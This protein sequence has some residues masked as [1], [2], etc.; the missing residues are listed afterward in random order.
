MIGLL[1]SF[2]DQIN[3]CKSKD[4]YTYN[5]L[6]SRS[7]HRRSTTGARLLRRDPPP[8]YPPALLCPPPATTP[9]A[10]TALFAS[11]W[12]SRT[13][14]WRVIGHRGVIRVTLTRYQNLPKKILTAFHPVWDPH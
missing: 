9:T 8:F 10:P 2:Y 11:P 4:D 14:R 5:T 6:P 1:W 12:R 3:L 13:W 7:H